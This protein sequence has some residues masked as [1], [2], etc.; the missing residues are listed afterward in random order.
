MAVSLG[1]DYM[2][3]Q[4][5]ICRT[6]R[7]Q[8]EEYVLFE[9]ADEVLAGL[10]QFCMQYPEP[11]VVV[12][13]DAIT[14]FASLASLSDERLER[15][16]L[17]YHPTRTCQEATAALRLVRGLS[18]HSSCAP[19]V[20][21]LPT[22]SPHRL[23][24]RPALGSAR[25]VCAVVALL[26]HMREQ[27]A[28]WEEMNFFCVNANEQGTSVLVI[29]NGQIV[30]GIK[31][32]QGSTL[33]AASE[34]LASLEGAREVAAEERHAALQPLLLEAF[35]EG[36]TQELAGLLAIHHLEDI[37]V[38]GKQSEQLIERLADTYQI[39]LFPQVDPKGS[40]YEAAL[41][42]ALLGE[43]LEQAGSSANVIEHLRIRQAERVA[44]V[45]G[46]RPA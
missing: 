21:Y 36:L 30:N 42:A 2:P 25:E 12:S 37:V 17:L 22:V 40:G 13:L 45:P 46:S 34:R 19:S 7:G 29:V 35:W 41:G 43:G 5:R 23:L 11:T 38:F 3:G 16:A 27:G 24:L 15:L 1:L 9:S 39:Y 26:H 8:P 20:E 4:W 31:T 18:L 10:R 44:L 33:S 32:L 6:E 28:T 14:P